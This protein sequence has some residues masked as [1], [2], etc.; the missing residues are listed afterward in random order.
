[1][2]KVLVIDNIG[3]IDHVELGLKRVNI[4]IGPQSAGKS[5]IL[6][7][8]C[9]CA[10]AEKRIQ[11]EQG[12]NGFA[13]AQYMEEQ[14][15]LFHK[16]G[17]F[18]EKGRGAKFR[19][20]TEHVWLQYEYDKE[21]AFSW[22]W[23]KSGHWGYKRSRISY[24]PA[25]RNVVATIPNWME[26]SMKSNNIRNFVSDWMLSRTFYNKDHKL[27][28]LGLGVK[29]YF[30]EKSGQDFIELDNGKTLQFTNGSSGIQSA[31]PMLVYLGFLFENQYKAGQYGKIST[32]TENEETL[33]HIYKKRRFGYGLKKYMESNTPYIGKIGMGKRVFKSAQ[34]YKECK[35]IFDSFTKTWR[36]DIYLKEPEQNLFPETQVTLM[37]RLLTQSKAHQDSIFIATHSPYILYALNNAMLAYYVQDKVIEEV[38][39]GISCLDSSYNPDD[40][41]AWQIENGH[42]V[43]LDDKNHTIQDSRHLI[44]KNFFDGIM[45]NIMNDFSNMANFYEP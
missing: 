44:R 41:A 26:V 31:V 36:S 37:Y 33:N 14:L 16:L 30:D 23:S 28:V 34:D 21:D 1:M 2:K 10:W 13:D 35:E 3:P 25:E 27:D 11:L 24:I 20:E 8:A 9:F 39:D 18:F 6:K 19:Y 40:V 7:I 29:Y 12:E 15:I 17:G 4:I 42:L 22:G 45:G 32:E 43:G 38:R 5:C